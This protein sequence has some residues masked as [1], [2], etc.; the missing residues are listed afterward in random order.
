MREHVEIC[1]RRQN[2]GDGNATDSFD[3]D[4]DD[5]DEESEEEGFA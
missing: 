4:E 5:E 2:V 1:P 3:E